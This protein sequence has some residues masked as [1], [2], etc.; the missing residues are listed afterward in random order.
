MNQVEN[1][2]GYKSQREKFYQIVK[3]VEWWADYTR[4]LDT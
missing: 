2:H 1:D 3:I 4:K